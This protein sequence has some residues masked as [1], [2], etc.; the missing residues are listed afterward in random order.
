MTLIFVAD[1]HAVGVYFQVEQLAHSA[2]V[3]KHAAALYGAIKY[4]LISC[5]GYLERRLRGKRES[6]CVWMLRL[7][8]LD[9]IL[10]AAN[11]LEECKMVE[12]LEDTL[13]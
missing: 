10:W 8:D 2:Q 3:K 9:S 6:Y 1:K 12:S 13:D 4:V 5:V 11:I 7:L